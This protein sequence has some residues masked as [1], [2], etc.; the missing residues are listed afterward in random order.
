MS[1]LLLAV[2]FPSGVHHIEGMSQL[3]TNERRQLGS[4]TTAQRS[5]ALAFGVTVGLWVTPGFLTLTLGSEHPLCLWFRDHIPEGVAAILGAMLLFILPGDGQTKQSSRVLQWQ[6]AAGIDWGIILLYGGGM[7]LGSLAFQTG[8]AEA[9][10]KGLTAWLPSDTSGWVLIGAAAVVA[11]FTSEF[12]SNTASANMVVPV[13]IALASAS[14]GDPLSTAIA[15]TLAASLGFMMPV[16]TP[17][18]AIV[19]GTGRVPLRSMMR[20][21]IGLDIA[22]AVT[23]TLVVTILVPLIFQS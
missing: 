22:G 3:V 21:G 17:C 14:G 12:T 23:V 9:I 11:V 4:W 1:T 2:S 15:A 19:Y 20:A 16:S 10:G 13:A 18:N 8:L 7:A 5:T 6:Q